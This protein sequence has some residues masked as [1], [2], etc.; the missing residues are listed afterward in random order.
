M[1]NRFGIE[2][3]QTS[4]R[5]AAAEGVPE[6]I[7]A[8]VLLLD[9]RDV[10]E[11]VGKLTPAELADVVRL[12]SRCPSCYP[13]VVYDALKAR[14]NVAAE[15]PPKGIRSGGA[16]NP[17]RGHTRAPAD[18]GPHT[19]RAG[20]A[21]PT[22]RAQDAKDSIST[23]QARRQHSLGTSSNIA[24]ERRAHVLRA[25]HLLS[26]KPGTRPGT[27]AETARRRM[28]VEE[29]MKAGLSVRTTSIATDI[30][31]TSVH[32]HARCGAGAS[33]ARDCCA[34]NY[35]RVSEKISAPQVQ[36]GGVGG[37]ALAPNSIAHRRLSTTSLSHR[38]G[39][40]G[41]RCSY[42]SAPGKVQ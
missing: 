17:L 37:L 15:Q 33:E 10:E 25:A 19:E 34:E 16:N 27:R 30:P 3:D 9:E 38:E 39:G 2:L 12:V 41:T 20:L 40:G 13:P 24:S 22:S 29:L 8:A 35:G 18:L 32:R 14:R 28:V 1:S 5:W 42:W 23:N 11:M 36:R 31:P 6:T 26:R 7:I 21:Q 4:L